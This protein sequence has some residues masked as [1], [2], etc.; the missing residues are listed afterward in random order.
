MSDE[1]KESIDDRIKEAELKRIEA[2]ACKST[3]RE[4]QVL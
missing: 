4:S 1:D 3:S 2:E